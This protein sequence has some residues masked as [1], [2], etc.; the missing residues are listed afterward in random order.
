MMVT[1]RTNGWYESY[2][3]R[4]QLMP[5]DDASGARTDAGGGGAVGPEALGAEVVDEAGAGERLKRAGGKQREEERE[6][7]R[8]SNS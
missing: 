1:S 6:S 5:I 4:Q 2:G 7:E 3:E 8:R